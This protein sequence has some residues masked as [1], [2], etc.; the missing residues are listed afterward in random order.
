MT[1][2]FPTGEQRRRWHRIGLIG[3]LII[4]SLAVGAV[5]VALR[6]T[7]NTPIVAVGGVLIALDLPACGYVAWRAMRRDR[8]SG[9]GG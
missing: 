3:G 7:N 9:Q 1:A 8:D 6:F 5:V 2:T 4:V